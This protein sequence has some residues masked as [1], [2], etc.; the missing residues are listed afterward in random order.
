MIE[1]FFLIKTEILSK[2][3][4][5]SIFYT[6]VDGI[7]IGERIILRNEGMFVNYG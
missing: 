5:V 1:E 2:P 3:C 6:C 7:V 4:R